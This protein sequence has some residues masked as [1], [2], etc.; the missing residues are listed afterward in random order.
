MTVVWT[1]GY[2]IH[3]ATVVDWYVDCIR[4]NWDAQLWT[5]RAFR[6]LNF[7]QET[8][9]TSFDWMYIFLPFSRAIMETLFN[10]DLYRYQKTW[11]KKYV[12]ARLWE[13]EKVPSIII[14]I[15]T[16]YIQS[17]SHPLSCL[18]SGHPFFRFIYSASYWLSVHDSEPPRIMMDAQEDM[19]EVMELLEAANHSG[20]VELSLEDQMIRR[21]T[22]YFV[23]ISFA[24]IL[25][26]GVIGNILVIVVVSQ[27]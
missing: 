1:G 23:P 21:L 5:F 16:S 11:H 10:K 6:D 8:I 19:A 2:S 7:L 4:S 27:S 24:I 18:G 25:I 3:P 26:T 22:L 17:P 15:L 12:T 13:W 14:T 9:F 20:E